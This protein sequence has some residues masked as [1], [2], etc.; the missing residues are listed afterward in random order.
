MRAEFEYPPT[1]SLEYGEADYPI[2][3]DPDFEPDM[4]EED[5]SDPIFHYL[6]RYGTHIF[7][8]S[9][10]EASSTDKQKDS[11][12][13]RVRRKRSRKRQRHPIGTRVRVL[14]P[15]KKAYIGKATEYDPYTGIYKVEFKDGEWEEFDDDEICFFKI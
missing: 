9:R 15:N 7:P 4:M 3:G 1:I 2:H 10:S 5:G 13:P 14:E 8:T 12:S 11:A 6:K